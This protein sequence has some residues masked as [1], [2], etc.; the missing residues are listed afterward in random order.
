MEAV[1][2]LRVGAR[3]YS[4]EIF[5]PNSVAGTEH[6]LDIPHVN[7][8]KLKQVGWKEKSDQYLDFSLETMFNRLEEKQKGKEPG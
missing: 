3:S 4:Y 8:M 2:S 1:C 7:G 6:A 5:T